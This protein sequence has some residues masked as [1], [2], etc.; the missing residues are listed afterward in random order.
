MDGQ[1]IDIQNVPVLSNGQRGG[2]FTGVAVDPDGNLIV[3]SRSQKVIVKCSFDVSNSDTKEVVKNCK[4]VAGVEGQGGCSTT[5]FNDPFG[6][7]YRNKNGQNQ[8]LVTDIGCS[9][10]S[11][12]T[13]GTNECFRKDGLYAYGVAFGREGVWVGQMSSP[14]GLLKC[15]EDLSS[16]AQTAIFSGGI[17][18]LALDAEGSIYATLTDSLHRCTAT[19]T[20]CMKLVDL[21]RS[22][23]GPPF[24]TSSNEVLVASGGASNVDQCREVSGVWQCVEICSGMLQPWAAIRLNDDGQMDIPNPNAC[25]GTKLDGPCAT[26]TTCGESYYVELGQG[27]QCGEVN[28]QCLA[29]GPLCKSL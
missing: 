28:A 23:G 7:A 1:A 11:L 22:G 13:E 17:T 15:T 3:N 14:F 4:A 26:A 10:V 8:F 12:C 2:E 18:G 9:S 5:K 24:V 20:D 25:R 16:C 19:G 6:F 29:T 21:P 27:F